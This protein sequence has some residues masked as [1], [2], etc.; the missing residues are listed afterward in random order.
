MK[1]GHALPILALL[2]FGA[3]CTSVPQTYQAVV[4]VTPANTAGYYTVVCTV[5][6]LHDGQPDTV[7]GTGTNTVPLG[8]EDPF[9]VCGESEDNGVL[10]STLC[11]EVSGV[12]GY[13]EV[14]DGF[15]TATIVRIRRN[16]KDVWSSWL[17]SVTKRE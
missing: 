9:L 7:L 16:G 11:G 5:S 4:N 10:C 12:Q 8:L 6:E 17:T 3:G 2:V 15:M 1:I 14:S 13:P